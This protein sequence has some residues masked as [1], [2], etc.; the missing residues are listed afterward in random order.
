MYTKIYPPNWGKHFLNGIRVSPIFI[1][2]IG[3]INMA[4]LIP[5][6]LTVMTRIGRYG[7]FNTGKLSTSIGEFVVKDKELDQ[8]DAGKYQGQFEIEKIKSVH[9]TYGNCLIV[10]C[11]AYLANMILDSNDHLTEEEIESFSTKEQDPLEE[12]KLSTSDIPQKRPPKALQPSKGRNYYK[13]NESTANAATD[14][15]SSDET[16]FGLLWPLANSIKLDT[17]IDRE[18]MRK[19]KARLEQLGYKFDFKTQLWNLVT[20]H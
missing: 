12:E 4:I 2:F 10:E 7:A 5:G 18:I 9:Y 19:Q 16:L 11:R 1:L 14:H 8:Y 17:T 20:N 6:T 3:D 13:P 15:S